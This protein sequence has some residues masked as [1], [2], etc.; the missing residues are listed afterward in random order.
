M[1][2]K[3]EIDKLVEYHDLY[4]KSDSLLLEDVFEKFKKMCSEIYQIDPAPFFFQPQISLASSFK[5]DRSKLEII[6]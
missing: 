4:L 6:S 3:F 1:Y 5:K 2:A